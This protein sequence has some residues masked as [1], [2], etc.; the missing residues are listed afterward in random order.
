LLS[1]PTT[2]S[3]PSH[4]LS[5][6]AFISSSHPPPTCHHTTLPPTHSLPAD[7]PTVPTLHNPNPL[8]S[9]TQA[10]YTI[11][12]EIH[13]NTHK[14]HKTQH[15]PHHFPHLPTPLPASLFSAILTNFPNIYI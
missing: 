14:G 11:L 10:P 6:L 12:T 8:Q 2:L 15:S 1:F 13:P 5:P 3:A 4:P 9:P 7:Q